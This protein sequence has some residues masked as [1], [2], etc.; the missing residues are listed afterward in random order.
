MKYWIQN[1]NRLKNITSI[2]MIFVVSGFSTAQN[3]M[4]TVADLKSDSE[5]FSIPV[6]QP[7]TANY[8]GIIETDYIPTGVIVEDEPEMELEKW[9]A[10]TNYLGNKKNTTTAPEIEKEQEM[11][12]ENWMS[13]PDYFGEIPQTPEV[14]KEEEL[15]LESWM[16]D[17]HYFEAPVPEVEKEQELKIEDWMS[18]SDYWN[19][20]TP[21]VE[22]EDEL[23]IEDWMSDS[24]YWEK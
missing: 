6:E 1:L 20:S 5:S 17:T 10:D 16:A 2:I 22:N 13:D 19:T 8:L 18:D 21:S 7:T 11:N 3:S 14:E 4:N 24:N 15:A 23:K 12:L 9:M